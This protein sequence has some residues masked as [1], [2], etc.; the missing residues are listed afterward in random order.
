[1]SALIAI[2]Y[3]ISFAILGWGIVYY[4]VRTDNDS[5]DIDS[6][7]IILIGAWSGAL[8]ACLSMLPLKIIY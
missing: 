3:V 8:F 4:Y 7:D 6:F 2:G 5:F 1:M